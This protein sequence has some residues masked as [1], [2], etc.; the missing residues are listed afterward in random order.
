MVV[1]ELGVRFAQKDKKT[2]HF[3]FATALY[4]LQYSDKVLQYCTGILYNPE[5]LSVDS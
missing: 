3:E 4:T 2:D 1:A 5:S